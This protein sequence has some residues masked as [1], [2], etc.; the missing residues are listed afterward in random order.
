MGGS[1]VKHRGVVW[2][3]RDGTI[4]DDPGYLSDP[5]GLVLLP[6]AAEGVAALN[7]GGATVVLVTN[8]SGIGRGLF[9]RQ[10]LDAVHERLVQQLAAAGARLDDLRVC[11]HAPDPDGPG[12]SCRKPRP[13]LVLDARRELGIE[14]GTP[15]VVVGDKAADVQL[16]ARIGAPSVLVLTGEG[17]R[18]LADLTDPPAHVARDLGAAV[19]WILAQLGLAADGGNC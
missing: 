9:T 7:R 11:P 2:L 3:D 4:V 13:G 6:G 1:L 5:D 10:Q 15:E 17:A 18:T 19:P 12:C 14:A 16:G 8:Q